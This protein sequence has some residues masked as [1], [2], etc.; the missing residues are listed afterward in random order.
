MEFML[1]SI[2]STYWWKVRAGTPHRHYILGMPP[3]HYTL[4]TL[5]PHYTLIFSNIA[6]QCSDSST[7][8][9]V[10]G[11]QLILG[12]EKQAEVFDT[13]VMANLGYYQLKATPGV[14]TLRLREGRSTDIYDIVR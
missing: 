14:W 6:G 7:D 12:T 4:I 11:L 2:W 13:I 1:H 5:P 3:P 10:P 9:P 8:S